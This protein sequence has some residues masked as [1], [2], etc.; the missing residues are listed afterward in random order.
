MKNVFA[1]LLSVS[2]FLLPPVHTAQAREAG[3]EKDVYEIQPGD[4][5][6]ISVW[7]EP[8]LLRQVMVRPDGGLSFPLIGDT[9]A[10]GMSVTELQDMISERLAKYIPEPVVT[11]STTQI[12]GN[13][14]Y[15]IGQVARPGEF[16]A[17]RRID[18][19]QA[20]SVAGGMTPY[21]STN[22]IKILRRENGVLT[23]IPFRYGDIE[24]GKHLDQDIMLES[25]DVVLVP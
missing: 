18:V 24:K 4:T 13:K 25:G 10:A 19:V 9:R 7:K 16:V 15:V 3:T 17:N 8:D 20:L 5:L 1:T 12:A 23:A 21:A 2:L 14:I 22:S 6:E 11:V